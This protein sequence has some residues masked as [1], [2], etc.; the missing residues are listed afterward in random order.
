MEVRAMAYDEH[1]ARMED[2]NT[3]AH[4]LLMQPDETLRHAAKRAVRRAERLGIASV[5]TQVA[6]LVVG[7]SSADDGA[8]MWR[9][10]RRAALLWRGE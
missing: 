4:A 3:V 5:R 2:W 1:V 7:A 8:D 6:N 10:I 9:R